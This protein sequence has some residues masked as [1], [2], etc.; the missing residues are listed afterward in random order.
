[1]KQFWDWKKIAIVVLLVLIAL[2]P[3]VHQSNYIMHVTIMFFIWG[4]VASLWNLLAGYAGVLS[5]GNMA[6]LLI[7]GYVS[8]VLSKSFGVSPWI[9]ILIAALVTMIVVTIILGLPALRLTGIYV[10]L[11]TIIF[12]D[13]L[14]SLLTQT[15]QY[16]GGAAGLKEIPL[17]WPGIE[18]IH[19]YYLIFSVFLVI[20][21]I[22]YRIIHSNTGLA[23]QA[24]RDDEDLALSL[25]V[26]LYF[27]KIKVFAVCSF[28]TGLIGG[29]Y[30]HYLSSISPATNSLESF[31]LAMCMIFLG[32]MA[33]FPG[34]VIGAL[35]FTINN[36]FMQLTRPLPPLLI[37]RNIF[38]QILYLPD[39]FMQ[40]V[41]WID[42]K[43]F[44]RSPKAVPKAGTVLTSVVLRNFSLFN[45]S[46]D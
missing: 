6:F 12:S 22:I 46:R 34:A 10:A 36:Q 25:G 2:A 38:V 20:L 18:R 32:G 13:A 31:M 39:G 14:P 44:K 43:I 7:G 42:R 45:K 4:V 8:G 11:L 21:A 30:V 1:M 23:F 40:I 26:N 19:A 9:A 27:E 3:L 5:L 29:V 17:F 37:G 41:D 15:R 33:R 28:F 24:M 16:T 35:F